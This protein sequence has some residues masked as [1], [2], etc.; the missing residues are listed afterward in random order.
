MSS[1]Q[2]R[3]SIFGLYIKGFSQLTLMFHDMCVCVCMCVCFF[4][5]YVQ[6]TYIRDDIYC[7]HDGKKTAVILWPSYKVINSLC[8]WLLNWRKVIRYG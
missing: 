1:V 4:N 3:E 8:T 2:L 5:D 7:G 6:L